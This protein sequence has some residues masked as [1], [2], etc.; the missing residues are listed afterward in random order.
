MLAANSECLLRLATCDVTYGNQKILDNL[1]VSI[2]AGDSIGIHAPSGT[3]KSTLLRAI[4]GMQ[5]ITGTRF[6]SSALTCREQSML[7]LPAQAYL[8]EQLSTL[9]NALVGAVSNGMPYSHAREQ[10]HFYAKDLDITEVLHTP[11]NM[12][13]AGQKQRVALM[14]ILIQKPIIVCLDEPTSHL[15]HAS[16]QLV[17]RMLETYLQNN[18]SNALIIASHDKTLLSWCSKRYLLNEGTLH[19]TP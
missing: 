12:L 13:S 2:H 4:A 1:N 7:Y 10:A 16:A 5:K 3:G 14:R 8:L 9:D 19:E 15:D 17:M 18:P 11:T 6:L